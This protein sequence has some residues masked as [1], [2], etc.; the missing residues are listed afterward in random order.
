MESVGD[1]SRRLA[2][3]ESQ[4]RGQRGASGFPAVASSLCSIFLIAGAASTAWHRVDLANRVP[5][6][7]MWVLIHVRG[8]ATGIN[9][10]V[11]VSLRSGPG[12]ASISA[13]S[14]PAVGVAGAT[15]AADNSIWIPFTGGFDV[16][17]TLAGTATYS[18]TLEGFEVSL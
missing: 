1:L 8:S 7:C 10:S 16:A 4:I 6:G 13:I 9:G 11:Q 18:L 3:V 12:S 15:V 14:Q 5:V 2:Q 17:T